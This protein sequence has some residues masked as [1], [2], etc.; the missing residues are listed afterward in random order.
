MTSARRNL[1]QRRRRLRRLISP[2]R[3]KPFVTIALTA[4]PQGRSICPRELNATAGLTR[5]CFAPTTL[6]VTDRKPL[7]VR[8]RKHGR[9]SFGRRPAPAAPPPAH[10]LP[11]P[12]H[13][14]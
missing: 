14:N 3:R 4:D 6:P 11:L 1:R 7:T 12:A 9:G 8:L 10:L 13:F 2:K 5:Q